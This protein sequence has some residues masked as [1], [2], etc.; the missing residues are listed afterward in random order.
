MWIKFEAS[1]SWIW[2]KMLNKFKDIRCYLNLIH[3]LPIIKIYLYNIWNS[4]KSVAY[5]LPYIYRQGPC[6]NAVPAKKAPETYSGNGRG[7]SQP[8]KE[9]R[10]PS[11]VESVTAH[12]RCMFDNTSGVL[13]V[14]EETPERLCYFELD[15]LN[16]EQPIALVSNW[17]RH[18]WSAHHMKFSRLFRNKVVF[19]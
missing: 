13:V 3:I 11:E 10:L 1:W 6:I 7:R 15:D 2:C 18:K 5:F 9:S 8:P 17:F 12:I 4:L 14:S 16:V 19:E